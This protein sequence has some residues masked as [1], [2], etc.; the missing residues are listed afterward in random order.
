MKKYISLLV[1]DLIVYRNIFIF[2]AIFITYMNLLTF[3]FLPIDKFV[4]FINIS[5]LE[6]SVFFV[7]YKLEAQKSQGE[8]FLLTTSYTRKN[9]ISSRYAIAFLCTI[10]EFVTYCC[11]KFLVH[12]DDRIVSPILNQLFLSFIVIMILIPLSFKKNVKWLSIGF[13]VIFYAVWNFENV[14]AF[15]YSPLFIIINIFATFT[16]GLLSIKLSTKIFLSQDF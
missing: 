13:M 7:L 15:L 9:L 10:F 8:E 14:F 16:L 12:H 5:L 11:G 6:T 3:L 2:F 1:K 4:S